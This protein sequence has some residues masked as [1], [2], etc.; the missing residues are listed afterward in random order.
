MSTERLVAHRIKCLLCGDILESRGG[1]ERIE[2]SCPDDSG[3]R[4]FIAGGVSR[5]VLG[6]GYKSEYEDISEW[7]EI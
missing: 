7:E 5:P 1:K 2:C 6:Y 3:T 4:V